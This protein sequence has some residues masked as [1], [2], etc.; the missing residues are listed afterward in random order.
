MSTFQSARGGCTCFKLTTRTEVSSVLC[1]V[2]GFL[3]SPTLLLN[4]NIQQMTKIHNT[5]IEY[6]RATFSKINSGVTISKADY[7]QF[8]TLPST[9]NNGAVVTSLSGICG[10]QYFSV[11][12]VGQKV[13]LG[14]RFDWNLWHSSHMT[15]FLN[16]RL[17]GEC[18][19]V[20][21]TPHQCEYYPRYGNA[22]PHI[23]PSGIILACAM[24][25]MAH[26]F[27]KWRTEIFAMRHNGAH[28]LLRRINK[29][30]VRHKIP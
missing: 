29:I 16:M 23:M 21:L 11:V 1:V 24:C 27:L 28:F 26:R 19:E 17:I 4:T 10:S 2:D 5:L 7:A 18:R 8:E 15:C 13:R 12:F 14:Q 9:I 3:Y 6:L 20:F 30:L 25:A 22:P